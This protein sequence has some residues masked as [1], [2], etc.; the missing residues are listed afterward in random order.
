MVQI[1]TI[2]CCFKFP[3]STQT[4]FFRYQGKDRMANGVITPDP[5]YFQ[6]LHLIQKVQTSVQAERIVLL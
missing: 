4:P 1:G 5:I 2:T 3:I 6:D